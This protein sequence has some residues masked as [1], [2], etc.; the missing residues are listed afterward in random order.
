MLEPQG[1][2]ADSADDTVS[3]YNFMDMGRAGE[4]WASIGFR[5]APWNRST[6]NLSLGD[7]I[8]IACDKHIL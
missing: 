7:I 2:G 3:T 4:A 5:K 8:E 1:G 6:Q